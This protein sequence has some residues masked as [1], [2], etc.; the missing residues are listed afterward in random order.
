MARRG[1]TPR[2]VQSGND[3]SLP[4]EPTNPHSIERTGSTI[5][6]VPAI[7]QQQIDREL[8]QLEPRTRNRVQRLV[9]QVA[10]EVA[11]FSGPLPPPSYLRE[12]EAITPGAGDRII[13]MTEREQQ[14]RHAWERSALSNTTVGLCFGFLIALALVGGGIY[15]VT[16]GQ[17]YVAGGFLTASAIGMVPALIKGRDFVVQ[18]QRQSGSQRTRPAPAKGS[19]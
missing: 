6:G 10:H 13:S 14:H 3:A 17:P 15:S 2:P 18:R 19:G 9:V 8:S 7:V 5:T 1:R 16:V 12:Y 4:A 11:E